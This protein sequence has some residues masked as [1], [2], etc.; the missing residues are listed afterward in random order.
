MAVIYTP[1]PIPEIPVGFRSDSRIPG[2]FRSDSGI[3]GGFQVDSGIPGGFRVDS[4]V[5]TVFTMFLYLSSN[6]AKE[7]GGKGIEPSTS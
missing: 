7:S 3:P 2:G 5:R 6:Q 4:G 1:L